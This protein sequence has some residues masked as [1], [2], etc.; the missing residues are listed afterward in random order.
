MPEKR[1]KLILLGL[2]VGAV[3]GLFGSGGGLVAVPMLQ[4]QGLDVKKSHAMAISMTAVFSLISASAYLLGGYVSLGVALKYIPFGIIGAIVG[5][6][7]LR[8]ISPV[9][10]KRIFG[11]IMIV[12]GVRILI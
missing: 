4:R 11:A 12:S 7:L 8:R 9:I 10:I 3:N 5:A 6:R 1:R 2:I